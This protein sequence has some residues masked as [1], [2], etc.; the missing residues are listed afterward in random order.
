MKR[1]EGG[2]RGQWS[3]TRWGRGLNADAVPSSDTDTWPDW[4]F[5]SFWFDIDSITVPISNRRRVTRDF[6]V[7][8]GRTWRLSNDPCRTWSHKDTIQT[9]LVEKINS[10][11]EGNNEGA[12]G[13]TLQATRWPPKKKTNKQTVPSTIKDV[14]QTVSKQN[15]K[16]NSYRQFECQAAILV[17]CS[18]SQNKK[19]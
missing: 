3:N 4:S 9:T 1:T 5:R 11:N 10:N 17:R 19:K 15:W 6:H 12:N 14:Y 13:K 7:R 2:R 16:T 18:E 8:S